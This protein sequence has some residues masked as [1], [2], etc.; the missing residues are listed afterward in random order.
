[1]FSKAPRRR[2]ALTPRKPASPVFGASPRAVKLPAHDREVRGGLVREGGGEKRGDGLRAGAGRA[3]VLRHWVYVLRRGR[4][5]SFPKFSRVKDGAA[6][7]AVLQAHSVSLQKV[8]MLLPFGCF[9]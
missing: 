3:P 8:G 6:F 2:G 4:R 9:L 7:V 1:M 5:I